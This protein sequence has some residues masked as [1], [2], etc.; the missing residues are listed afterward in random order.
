MTNYHNIIRGFFAG[1]SKSEDCG[2]GIYTGTKTFARFSIYKEDPL[3]A[4]PTYKQEIS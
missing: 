1:V 3:Q 2:Y 4:T